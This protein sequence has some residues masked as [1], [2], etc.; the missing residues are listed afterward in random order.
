LKICSEYEYQRIGFDLHH[1]DES[2][3][4][5]IVGSNQIYHAAAYQFAQYDTISHTNFKNY[6]F[7]IGSHYDQMSNY[8]SLTK[9]DFVI[10]RVYREDYIDHFLYG[11]PGR[12]NSAQRAGRIGIIE[13]S[14]TYPQHQCGVISTQEDAM[15]GTGVSYAVFDNEQWVWGSAPGHKYDAIDDSKKGEVSLLPF[16]SCTDATDKDYDSEKVLTITASHA[17]IV[18]IIGERASI[19]FGNLV[20]SLGD[21]DGA[22]GVTNSKGDLVNGIEYVL[23]SNSNSKLDRLLTTPQIFIF[24][25]DNVDGNYSTK[26]VFYESGESGSMLGGSA[27]L[28]EDINGDG[29]GEIVISHPYGVGRYGLTGNVKIFSGIEIAKQNASAA[30][31][32]SL[33]NPEDQQS[34]FGMELLYADITGDG[35]KD[36]IVS[37]SN[38]STEERAN[39]GAIYVFPVKPITEKR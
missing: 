15:L 5:G 38:Y 24:R 37:A 29:I 22:S 34:N 1:F 18:E 33:F 10:D 32:Q 3:S 13:Y 4:L 30:L 25:I 19:G 36:F 31:I 12:Y 16:P 23:I 2:N 7:S 6:S 20:L 17:D 14:G 35:L 26:L 39:V 8:N 27:M 21:L 11:E 9:P 28:I